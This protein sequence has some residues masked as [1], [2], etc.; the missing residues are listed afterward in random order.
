M[1]SLEYINWLSIS[2]NKFVFIEKDK[3][4]KGFMVLTA[5]KKE[6]FLHSIWVDKNSNGLSK[7]FYEKMIDFAKYLNIK[8]IKARMLRKPYG[9]MKKWGF[10]LHSYIIKKEINELHN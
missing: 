7:Q 10:R 8:T 3:K 2:Q 9:A 1:T 5:N 4:I 6:L